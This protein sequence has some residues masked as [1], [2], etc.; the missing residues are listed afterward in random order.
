MPTGDGGRLNEYE[1]LF[2]PVPPPSQAQP[3]QRVARAK[4]SVQTS[5]DAELVVQGNN[6]KNGVSPG[7]QGRADRLRDGQKGLNH[8]VSIWPA[9]ARTSTIPYGRDCGEP[10]PQL[11]E[12]FGEWA[13]EAAKKALDEAD[14]LL[15]PKSN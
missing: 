3:E 10:H 13:E 15:D 8:R 5:E 11:H 6:L 9:A 2:P 14:Q 7:V 1:G 4:A 12:H